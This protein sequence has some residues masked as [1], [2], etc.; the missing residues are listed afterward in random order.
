MIEVVM[1]ADTM[2]N[3]TKNAGGATAAFRAD[4]LAN[5]LREHNNSVKYYLYHSK[6][7]LGLSL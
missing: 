4:P 2:A 6:I 1:N 5:W 7:L 3:I